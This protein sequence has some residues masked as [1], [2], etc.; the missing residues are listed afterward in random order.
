MK[1][2]LIYGVVKCLVRGIMKLYNSRQLGAL[3]IICLQEMLIANCCRDFQLGK[4]PSITCLG[5]RVGSF[6]FPIFLCNYNGFFS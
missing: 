2:F 6:L 1:T 3:P 4:I 5:S